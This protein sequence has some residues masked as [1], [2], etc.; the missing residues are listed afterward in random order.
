MDFTLKELLH[1][2]LDAKS[3][4]IHIS[5]G[6][7]PMMRKDGK[8]TPLID[9][10]LTKE[11]SKELCYQ[12][13]KP[14]EAQKFEKEWEIDTAI[15][16]EERARF[17]VNVFYQLE[18]VAAALRP[19]PT[20]MPRPEQLG[21]PDIIMD[22]A[23][24]PRGLI[25]VTG[26]TGSGKSTSMAAMV[27]EINHTRREH[28][29]TVEDPVEFIHTSK[30]SLVAHREVDRDTQSF[31]AALK[32]ILRQDPDIVL[33]GEMRDLETIGAAI[34]I[35]ETGHLVFGTLHTNTAVST[36]NRIIDVFPSSQ[37]A[38]IRTQLSF[39][40]QAVLSQ[41]LVPKIG[42][43]RCLGL[44]IMIPNTAIRNLI[45]EDK[46]HQIYAAMQVG[47]NETKMQTMNHCLIDHL[48]NNRITK[49]D[50]FAYSTQQDEMKKVLGI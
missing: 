21:L 50:A 33:V 42:G 4:D 40:L 39:V 10:V 7:P 5:A 45:R 30:K 32:R 48:K 11:E 13:L 31:A 49:E 16:L 35:A 2:M 12:A 22:I 17:R 8:L 23:K 18:T 36:I 6:A 20:E 19:I 3:S 1:K 27:N 46:V 34:T 41:Q 24:K 47:R 9:H 37:Q 28:I 38:Q 25:L 29:I 43:G 14:E 15:N 44:E 26:P